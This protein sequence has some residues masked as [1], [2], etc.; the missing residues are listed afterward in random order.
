[1]K[2]LLLI[3]DGAADRAYPELQDRT[4]LAYAH[5]PVMDEWCA[6][7]CLGRVQTIPK[8]QIPGTETAM[9]TL[10]MNQNE[11]FGRAALEAEADGLSIG[12]ACVYRLN[13]LASED[14]RVSHYF[15]CKLDQQ[16]QHSL[17]QALCEDTICKRTM[18]KMNVSI[19]QG[20]SGQYYLL[21]KGNAPKSTSPFLLMG[22]AYYEY[23]PEG[24]AKWGTSVA[25]WLAD[26]P[27]NEQR[28]YKNQPT[29]DLLWP[30]AE[31]SKPSFSHSIGQ[32]FGKKSACV[33]AT[34]FL[35]G[36]AAMAGM[37]VVHVTGATGGMDTDI[38]GKAIAA[39]EA[40][41]THDFVL[42]HLEA[43]DGCSHNRDVMGK[44]RAIEMGDRLLHSVLEYC[45]D[46]IQLMV[47]S[48]HVTFCE[49]GRHGADPVPY[50]LA[51]TKWPYMA[52]GVRFCEEEAQ[53]FGMITG[54]HLLECL[55]ADMKR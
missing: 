43:P 4:P 1:M 37:D 50:F 22:K 33:A 30:W 5:T 13:F 35:K 38:Q 48:D 18:E 6:K 41:H 3:L 45:E 28:R 10:L 53:A 51:N 21:A 34:P 39:V 14:Y 49:S 19:C 25:L 16:S 46:D 24:W 11:S 55:F 42:V 52:S 44:V 23:W 20:N 9:A 12:E 54:D 15:T 7:G 31:G 47:M 2:Y 27:I 36:M 29:F 32:H 17:I 40:L 8:K 26:H